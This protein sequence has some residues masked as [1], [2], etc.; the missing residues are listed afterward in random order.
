MN[1]APSE[2]LLKKVVDAV[3]RSVDAT[4]LQNALAAALAPT[5]Q[6]PTLPPP[7][8][9]SAPAAPPVATPGPGAPPPAL[10]ARLL[11]TDI[12]DDAI[13]GSRSGDK[14]YPL[15]LL[16]TLLGENLGTD[17]GLSLASALNVYFRVSM[18]E[19]V[20]MR[21]GLEASRL[22]YR[23]AAELPLD[24][25]LAA[26]ASPLLASVLSGELARVRFECVDSARV[27]DSQ[28]HERAEGSDA[29]SSQIR[30]PASFLCRVT[31]TG[32]LRARALVR[33]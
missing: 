3:V 18:D 12:L 8:P 1:R 17:T 16:F 33:T 4:K 23:F 21:L 24:P 25:A 32:M 28:V 5:E 31:A 9:A 26:Q 30:G 22:Y 7:A 29:A 10:A 2:E 20:K 11:L 6:A 27:F 19:E 14:A 15:R 13:L